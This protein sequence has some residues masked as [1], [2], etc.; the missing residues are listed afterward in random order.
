MKT[1]SA[2]EYLNRIAVVGCGHVGATSAYSLIMGG[3]A[4]EVVLIDSNRELVEGEA[5]G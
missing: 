2:N 3:V 4:R 5:M 1:G